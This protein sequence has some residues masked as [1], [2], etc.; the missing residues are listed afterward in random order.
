[1]Q[2]CVTADALTAAD[3]RAAASKH[4]RSDRMQIAV[5]ADPADVAARSS[6]SIPA[7]SA[8]RTS[9]SDG[10]IERGRTLRP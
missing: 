8:R 4:L 7:G 2:W 1:M 6:C 5:V 10:A 9:V 3:V